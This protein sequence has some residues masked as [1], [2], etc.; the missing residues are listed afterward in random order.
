M[1]VAWVRSCL[2]V[3]RAV[4]RLW[5]EALG[6][7]FVW[8]VVHRL[9]SR[10]G[11]RV[12]ATTR[13]G[14]RFECDLRDLVQ[15]R[16][17]Y[18]G[19]WEPS[20][21]RVFEETLAPGDVCLD[22]GANVGYFTVLAA[23]L[24][25]PTGRV[26]AIE[27]SPTIRAQLDAHVA[28]N[29]LRNVQV[30]GAAVTEREGPVAIYLGPPTNRGASALSMIGG[31]A[32]EAE[33]RGAPLRTLVSPDDLARARLIKIDIEGHEYPVL[34]E[35]LDHAQALRP[36]VAIVVELSPQQ[37]A[38]RGVEPGA[39]LAEFERAGFTWALLRHE[40]DVRGNWD[41]GATPPELADRP[42]TTVRDV[43]LT[44]VRRPVALPDDAGLPLARPGADRV[45]G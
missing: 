25:G 29:G 30:I 40:Y 39:L 22:V 15:S 13:W 11:V 17:V 23:R 32:R 8:R 33:V 19:V 27:A 12:A 1:R 37:L 2:A 35:L 16:L 21:T 34:R 41:V 38:A 36:D 18:A 10:L 26:V 3:N 9:S 28:L 7:G 43:F 20:L 42:P 45:P 31:G 5:P 24:V 44:R 4:L 6:R 14:G